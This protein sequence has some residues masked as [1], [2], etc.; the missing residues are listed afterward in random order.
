VW[1]GCGETAQVSVEI[2]HDLLGGQQQPFARRDLTDTIA[3]VLH[4]P[5]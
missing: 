2:L 5:T 4:R 1:N 3:G